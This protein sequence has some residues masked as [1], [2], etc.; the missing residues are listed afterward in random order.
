MDYR[1]V[2]SY[3]LYYTVTSLK[4][5]AWNARPTTN[6]M[7][8]CKQV[9]SV[10]CIFID[11]LNMCCQCMFLSSLTFINTGT[12]NWKTI[13]PGKMLHLNTQVTL[14]SPVLEQIYLATLYTVWLSLSELYIRSVMMSYCSLS[15]TGWNKMHPNKSWDV[16]EPSSQACNTG[17][18]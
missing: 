16:S 10:I 3:W 13:F 1:A 7:H 4:A 9:Y 8:S 11:L 2:V 6:R 18:A 14:K 15:P 5:Q 17:R 12:C